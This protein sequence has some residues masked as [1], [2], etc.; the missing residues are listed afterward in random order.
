MTAV[1]FVIRASEPPPPPPPPLEGPDRV[2]LEFDVKSNLGLLIPSLSSKTQNQLKILRKMPLYI[3][4]IM[5]WSPW[6]QGMS[7]L[8]SF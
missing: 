6:Q 5:K 1:N 4:L 8:Q 7:Y 3:S 2:K